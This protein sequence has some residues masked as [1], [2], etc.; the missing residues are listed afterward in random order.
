MTL[1]EKL[2]MLRKRQGWSQEEFAGRLDI[3]RQSV[4]KWE[5]G[6]SVPDLDKL[7][8]ISDIFGVTI[9]YLIKEDSE[10]EEPTLFPQDNDVPNP[11]KT[12]REVTRDEAESYMEVCRLA[13]RP[14][15]LAVALI[16]FSPVCILILVGLAEAGFVSISE[17]MAGGIGVAALLVLVAGS[18]AALIINGMK[19]SK[20]EYLEKELIY[21]PEGFAD[22]VLR[23]KDEF[24]P[25]LRAG[26]A[27]GVA[28][29]IIGVI[30]VIIAGAMGAEEYILIFAS[31]FVLIFVAAAVNIFVRLGII[32]AGFD[33]LLQVDDYA[34]EQKK[35]EKKLDPFVGAYWCI[36][37]AVYL[38]ISF[39]FNNW[40]RSWIVWPVAGVAF[41]AFYNI[42]SAVLKTKEK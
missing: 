4:S 20:Y 31:A 41:A 25:K 1:A 21:L 9:D 35:A 13:S 26:I 29:I 24:A 18:V 17:D 27:T 34:P 10:E 19:L 5:S 42:L 32:N 8:K 11:P 33:K 14:I 30:P 22:E 16:V 28:C 37:T 2:A 36:V 6:T 40:H 38:G 12:G 7:V 3:S 15:A 23:R 39:Y